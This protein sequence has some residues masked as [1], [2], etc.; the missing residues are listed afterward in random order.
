M[1]HLWQQHNGKPGRGKYHNGEWAK[2]MKRIGLL[3]FNVK[4]PTKET[5]QACSHKIEDGG[6]FDQVCA[7]FLPAAQAS[8]GSQRSI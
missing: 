6:A 1:A 3:P 5:G 7:E 8:I 4:D 2:E